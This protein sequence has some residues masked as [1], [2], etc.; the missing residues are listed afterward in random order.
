[1][2]KILLTISAVLIVSILTGCGGVFEKVHISR[3]LENFKDL[4]KGMILYAHDKEDGSFPK[5]LEELV[6]GDYVNESALT[7]KF[8]EKKYIYK[9][10]FKLTDASNIVIIVCTHGDKGTHILT[11]NGSTRAIKPGEKIPVLGEQIEE[12]IYK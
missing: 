2:K 3:C 1:M 4:A 10:G 9:P 7:C 5:N 11:V 6:A 12:F 8:S